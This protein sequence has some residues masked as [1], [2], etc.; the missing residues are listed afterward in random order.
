M[1]KTNANIFLC[2]KDKKKK[3]KIPKVTEIVLRS[4]KYN[5]TLI[6]IIMAE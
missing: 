5:K 2:K 1:T 3:Q 6:I 4:Q